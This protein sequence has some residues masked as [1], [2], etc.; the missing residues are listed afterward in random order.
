MATPIRPEQFESVSDL[1]SALADPNRLAILYLLKE[2]PAFV[3]EI[4]ETTGMKQSNVSKHLSVL[5]DAELLSRERVGNQIRYSIGDP[6]V[7][8][9]CTLVCRKLHREAESQAQVMRK[10]AR[11]NI[12]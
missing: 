4:I 5:Y 6:M 2:G 7:F 9:L 3:S 8:D 10:V 1:F 11:R 12:A